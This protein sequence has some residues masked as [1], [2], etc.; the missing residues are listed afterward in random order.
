MTAWSRPWQWQGIHPVAAGFLAAHPCFFPEWQTLCAP[1]PPPPPSLLIRR[2]RYCECSS[3]VCPPAKGSRAAARLPSLLA[4]VSVYCFPSSSFC[5]PLFALHRAPHPVHI[6]S[7]QPA[8]G[9]TH[10][11]GRDGQASTALG[12]NKEH[13]PPAGMD[14]DFSNR[15]LSVFDAAKVRSAL[16]DASAAAPQTVLSATST[17]GGDSGGAALPPPSPLPAIR[18]LNLSFNSLHLF[19][20]GETLKGLTVLDLSHNALAQ[21]YGQ[22]MPPTLVRLSIA[23]NRLAQ[24]CN[25]AQ[26]TP[27]LQVL[28]A[29]HNQLSASALRDLPASLTHL[30]VENNTIG[31]LR[32]LG[33]L[34]RLTHLNVAQNQLVST[35]TLGALRPLVSLRHLDVRGN[36]MCATGKRSNEGEGDGVTELLRDILPRL[37]HFNGASLSQ[38]PENRRWKMSHRQQQQQQTANLSTGKCRRILHDARS[39]S[40]ARQRSARENGSGGSGSSLLPSSQRPQHK[41]QEHSLEVRLMQAKVSELRRLLLAAQDAEGK[42][43]QDRALLV[44]N[45]QSTAKVIDQQEE[46]LRRLQREVE[47]LRDADQKL[48]LS[49]AAAEESFEQVHASL[50]ATKAKLSAS[51]TK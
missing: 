26:Y 19:T 51:V 38:A 37:S 22:S 50:L 2:S 33:T 49:V 4:P 29:G 13:K 48:R 28:E 1:P 40:G 17:D 3:T 32:P 42:A 23:H 12:D 25:L 39:G 36:P 44:E 21:L 45:V 6:S 43:R 8:W 20:G 10:T 15:G 5:L 47:S 14:L 31:S 9:C 16:V 46:E 11:D 41:P 30:S 18:F 34:L 24:V 7:S 27:R 35:D